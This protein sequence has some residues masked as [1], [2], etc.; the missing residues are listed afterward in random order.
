MARKKVFFDK[1]ANILNKTLNGWDDITYISTDM[2]EFVRAHD[3]LEELQNV[4][5]VL[6]E[7]E[8]EANNFAAYNGEEDDDE[9]DE[10]DYR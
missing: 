10:D 4:V 7:E 5:S 9:D 3:L 8:C 1:L 6:Q 2:P